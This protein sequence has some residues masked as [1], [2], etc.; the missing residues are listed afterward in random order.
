MQLLV[1]QETGGFEYIIDGISHKFKSDLKD[2]QDLYYKVLFIES[3]EIEA[4]A[5][6][7]LS[8]EQQIEVLQAQVA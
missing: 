2:D 5:E 8:K 7:T 4:S 6:A 1:N 3:T